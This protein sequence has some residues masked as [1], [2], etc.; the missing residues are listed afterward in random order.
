MTT[1][2][3]FT[4]FQY[5]HLKMFYLPTDADGTAVNIPWQKL[6]TK[7]IEEFVEKPKI[8]KDKAMG[9]LDPN[10][11]HLRPIKA[12]IQ[13]LANEPMMLPMR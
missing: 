11:A 7:S 1:I 2:D 5:L 3:Q 9:K 13:P 8:S 10:N 6:D 4:L 12:A